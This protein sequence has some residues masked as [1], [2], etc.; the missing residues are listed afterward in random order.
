MA[1]SE[2][3]SWRVGQTSLKYPLLAFGETPDQSSKVILRQLSTLYYYYGRKY[4]G[5]KL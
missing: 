1:V 5:R 3:T 2:E 4:E